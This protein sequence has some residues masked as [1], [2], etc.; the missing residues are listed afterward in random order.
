MA[1]ECQ[2]TPC[3]QHDEY[4]YHDIYIYIYIYYVKLFVLL[5]LRI[6]HF[7][8]MDFSDDV[9]DIQFYDDY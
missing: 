2:R 3:G 5:F 1:W 7:Y 6:T 9:L 4:D 8:E